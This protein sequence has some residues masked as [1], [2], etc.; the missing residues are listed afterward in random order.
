MLSTVLCSA[1]CSGRAGASPPLHSPTRTSLW[2]FSAWLQ[3][4]ARSEEVTLLFYWGL[5]W[6]VQQA[7]QEI[8]IQC[9]SLLEQWRRRC[10]P[11]CPALCF[12]VPK[13][14]CTAWLS[15]FIF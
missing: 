5:V 15:H 9:V 11:A 1:P 6:F 10:L 4:G 7:G 2:S 12:R 3:Q 8:N 14:L 13:P